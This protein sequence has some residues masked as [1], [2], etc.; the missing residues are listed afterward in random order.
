MRKILVITL[1]LSTLV[2]FA[3]CSN[4]AN[5]AADFPCDY[6]ARV[7]EFTTGGGDPVLDDVVDATFP[8]WYPGTWSDGDG[9]Y[10]QEWSRLILARNGFSEASQIEPDSTI[11]IPARCEDLG[12]GGEPS[13]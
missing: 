6:S 10:R 1:F 7:D 13:D 11:K 9:I 4:A 5:M 8:T 2:V 3:G 12:E